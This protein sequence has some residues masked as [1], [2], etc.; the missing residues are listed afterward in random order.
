MEFSV[1]HR[2]R[3]FQGCCRRILSSVGK[4]AAKLKR[5]LPF[6]HLD[7]RPGEPGFYRMTPMVAELFRVAQEEIAK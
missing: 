3:R 2:D 7:G 6:E 1:G 4:T 5:Q